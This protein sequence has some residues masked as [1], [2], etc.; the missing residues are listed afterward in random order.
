MPDLIKINDIDIEQLTYKGQPVV[1]FEM[2]AQVHSIPVKTVQKPF[3]RHRM[4]FTEGKHIYRLDFAQ[5]NLLRLRVGA[6]SNGVTLF[7][8]RGYLLLT[9][10]MRDERSWQVQE[11]M[12]DDYFVLRTRQRRATGMLSRLSLGVVADI[13]G[14]PLVGIAPRA[15]GDPWVLLLRD[16][17]RIRL[18]KITQQ[19]AVR[20]AI[21]ERAGHMIHRRTKAAYAL[22]LTIIGQNAPSLAGSPSHRRIA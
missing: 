15:D 7:T 4:R 6:N 10:P 17:Q 8:E 19:S 5:A 21:F 9:K 1:T 13:W 12:I 14:I 22:L 2:I 3:E 20:L 18:E 16:G 11:Q